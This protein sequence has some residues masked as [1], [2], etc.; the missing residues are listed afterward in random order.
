METYLY[1]SRSP[2]INGYLDFLTVQKKDG[3]I[4]HVPYTRSVYDYRSTPSA[5]EA[6]VYQP[7]K[8]DEILYDTN[9]KNSFYPKVNVGN[10]HDIFERYPSIIY[11]TLPIENAK[12]L[13]DEH[14]T[15]VNLQKNRDTQ[16]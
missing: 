11:P 12:Q 6:I 2:L 15:N 16:R 5:P 7:A 8:G 1:D 3:T 4:M 14:L 9:Q 10:L 13:I